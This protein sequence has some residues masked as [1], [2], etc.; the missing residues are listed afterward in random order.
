MTPMSPKRIVAW[1][2]V[3]Q[4]ILLTN[5][6]LLFVVNSL[7]G[8]ALAPSRRLATVP[9]VTHVLGAAASTIP[10]SFFMKRHGRRAG[11]VLGAALGV[12]GGLVGTLA[13]VAHSFALLL[14]GTFLLGVYSA[15]G[16][17]YRFAAADA[18]PPDWKS[19]AVSL[20]LAGGVVGGFIG[21]AL[22][23]YTR[24]LVQPQ[25]AASYAVLAVLALGSLAMVMRLRFQA[26]SAE[27]RRSATRPIREI[28]RQ[29]PVV[30]AIV[31]SAVGYGV[32]NL[33]MAATPLAM[34]LCCGHPFAAATFVLQWHTIG[35]FL[36][37]FFT[38]ALIKRAGVLNVLLS[39]AALLFACVGIA[40]HGLSVMHFWWALTLLG[41]GWNFLYIGGTTLL[42]EAHDPAEKAAVQGVNDFI[43]YVVMAT[44]ALAS[45]VVI[46]G[47]AGWARLT[48]LSVP[49]VAVT[50]LAT[51]VLWLRERRAAAAASA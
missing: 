34:D 30:V 29:P 41:V 24:D 10:A 40:M 5:G 8:F 11:F 51:A 20:T 32:M 46:T 23:R 38:G 15:F 28:L 21:P 13:I 43:V 36:P 50:A 33:L 35:M 26:Q 18:A 48:Q 31:A 1:L 49:F 47:S 22:G 39:G 17:Y 19:R 12:V 27:E 3:C 16:Q 45:G 37:S 4:T 2:A 14:A 44:T 6:V 25:F 9:L 7:A 42:T